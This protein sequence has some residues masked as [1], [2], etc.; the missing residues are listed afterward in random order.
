MHTG[1]RSAAGLAQDISDVT[2]TVTEED[3]Y[4]EEVLKRQASW[5]GDFAV[6]S[7]VDDDYLRRYAAMLQSGI[8]LRRSLVKSFPQNPLA[9]THLGSFLGMVGKNFGKKNLVD[10]GILEC[11]IAAGLQPNWDNPAVEVGIILVNI[12]EGAAA[13][14]ELEQAESNFPEPTPHLRFVK[15]YVLM[16]LEQHSEALACLEAVIEERPDFAPAYDQA[17][18]CAFKSGDRIKGLRYAKEARMRGMYA[19]HR[20]WGNGAYS[21]RPKR[22]A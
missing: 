3:H 5:N 12:S 7:P 4:I 16:T 21:S 20:A 17:A 13:L 2:G 22:P 8:D 9:H 18:H 14:R 15:G 1:S 6:E 19:E 10:E 11:K